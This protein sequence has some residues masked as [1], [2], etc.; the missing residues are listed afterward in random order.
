MRGLP[1]VLAA[2]DAAFSWPAGRPAPP[3]V[4][5]IGAPSAGARLSLMGAL[6]VFLSARL[7][8]LPPTNAAGRTRVSRKRACRLLVGRSR[9]PHVST[10]P[11]VQME[12][13]GI[14]A[15]GADSI[16]RGPAASRSHTNERA[17]PGASCCTCQQQQAASGA[18]ELFRRQASLFGRVCERA[19]ED[20]GKRMTTT[21]TRASPG[22][23]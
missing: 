19:S 4:A 13:N 1:A 7:S 18:P 22:A 21:T 2:G 20:A 12:A 11:V 17:P 10:S 23:P 5:G 14:L 9:R 8:L 16:W 6:I 15:S 3:P